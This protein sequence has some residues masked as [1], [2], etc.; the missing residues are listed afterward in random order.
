MEAYRSLPRFERI[1]R[2]LAGMCQQAQAAQQPGQV[3]GGGIDGGLG[4]REQAD[5]PGRCVPGRQ[6]LPEQ[7]RIPFGLGVFMRGGD[8][9]RYAHR[10]HDAV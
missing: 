6:H 5:L 8:R 9:S 1:D 10:S 2:I 3:G 4:L 7:H